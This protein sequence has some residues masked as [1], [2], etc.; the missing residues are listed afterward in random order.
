MYFN[1]LQDTYFCA[2]TCHCSCLWST[3]HHDDVTWS[4]TLKTP[5]PNFFYNFPGRVLVRSSLILPWKVTYLRRPVKLSWS[6]R[7][8]RNHTW[9][10]VPS[11]DSWFCSVYSNSNHECLIGQWRDN[12]PDFLCPW[13]LTC[14]TCFQCQPWAMPCYRGVTLE[15]WRDCNFDQ[16]VCIVLDFSCF[17]L[18]ASS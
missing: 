2:Y 10:K 14:A 1:L 9:A 4:W 12:A 15:Y 8:W 18:Q 6:L 13:R 17:I 3:F 11:S 5:C 7:I 16:W